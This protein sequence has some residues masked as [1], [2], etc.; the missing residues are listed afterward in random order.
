M[1]VLVNAGLTREDVELVNEE[2]LLLKRV[3]Y[4]VSRAAQL[5]CAPPTTT[6][7]WARTRHWPITVQ[8][9][10]N[11]PSHHTTYIHL[12]YDST[13][14]Q[15]FTHSHCWSDKA[16]LVFI[17]RGSHIKHS[18]NAKGTDHCSTLTITLTLV[19]M[20]MMIPAHKW[21]LICQRFWL[22]VGNEAVFGLVYIHL[23]SLPGLVDGW[24][25]KKSSNEMK[26]H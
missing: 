5:I 26:W 21:A 2:F 7:P 16:R 25:S 8:H 22:V 9:P 3:Y 11:T 6:A 10:A 4:W 14:M 12:L 19:M 1:L 18:N 23:G 13:V 20:M 15:R 17:T 24:K